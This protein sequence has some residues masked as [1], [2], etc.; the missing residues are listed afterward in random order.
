VPV[1][2]AANGKREARRLTAVDRHVT[3]FDW[4]PDGKKIVFSHVQSSLVD[5]WTTADASIVDVANGA[6]TSF[7]A[8]AAAESVAS[9]S[10]DGKWIAISVS[11]GPIRWAQSNRIHV[12]PIA[13]GQP[14]VMAMSH[15]GQPAIIGWSADGSKIMF[16][17]AKGTGTGVY[18]AVVATGVIKEVQYKDEVINNLSMTKDGT[19]YAF[20]AQSSDKA[21]EVFVV[22]ATSPIAIQISRTNKDRSKME[23]GKTEVLDGK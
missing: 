23:I 15:D 16:S 19:M 18:E 22:R 12:Y 5:H 7:S 17:E 11:D 2:K 9:Y 3:S 4:S 6:V 10:P 14:K 20:V 1:E 8:T 13:G 21:P